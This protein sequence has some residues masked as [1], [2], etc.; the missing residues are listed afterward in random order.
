MIDGEVESGPNAVFSF[1]REGYSKFSFSVKDTLESLTFPGFIKVAKKY[2]KVGAGEFYRSYSKRAFVKALQKLVP[3]IKGEDLEPGNAG[4][5]AQ[6]SS[7]DGGLLDDFY[8]VENKRV[9]HVCNAPSPA[10]TSSLSI[11]DYIAEKLLLNIN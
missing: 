9:I 11:G 5:R 8:F 3:E 6:A 4:V 2:W 1:K 7:R 10:A